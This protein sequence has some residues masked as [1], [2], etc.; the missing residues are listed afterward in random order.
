[1][2]KLFDRV[3]DVVIIDAMKLVLLVAFVHPHIF[4]HGHSLDQF[5]EMFFLDLLIEDEV[6]VCEVFPM[7]S[8]DRGAQL[9]AVDPAL[10]VLLQPYVLDVPLQL[11]SALSHYHLNDKLLMFRA[12]VHDIKLNTSTQCKTISQL[13]INN[14]MCF[15]KINQ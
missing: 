1:M 4:H 14:F 3:S 5:I 8:L 9:V 13:I 12:E 2:L 10:F 15:T 7:A 6:Q 11:L